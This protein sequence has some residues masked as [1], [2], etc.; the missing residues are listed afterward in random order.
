MSPSASEMTAGTSRT[1]WVGGLR[2]PGSD[3]AVSVLYLADE[4]GREYLFRPTARVQ[5]L[6]ERFT[7]PSEGVVSEIQLLARSGTARFIVSAQPEELGHE[8]LPHLPSLVLDPAWRSIYINASDQDAANE[9]FSLRVTDEPDKW[10][11]EIETLRAF[12]FDVVTVDLSGGDHGWADS[13][14]DVASVAF[15]LWQEGDDTQPAYEAGI[16]WALRIEKQAGAHLEWSLE[17][18]HQGGTK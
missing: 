13:A 16:R 11:A 5:S 14:L 9:T 18:L 2:S 3:S 4:S 1:E 17:P 8:I 10:A 7:P 15:L 6:E 12:H